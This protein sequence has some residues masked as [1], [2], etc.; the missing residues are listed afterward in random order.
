MEVYGE[1]GTVLTDDE[2]IL[3]K[4]KT[5]FQNIYNTDNAASNFDD[6]FIGKFQHTNLH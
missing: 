6:D 1:D 4:W 5:E 3:N 2:T